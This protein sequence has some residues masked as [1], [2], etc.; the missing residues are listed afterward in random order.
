LT[1]ELAELFDQLYRDNQAKVYRLALSLTGNAHDAEEITQEAFLRAF[2]SYQG[3]REE[4]SFFTWIYRIAINVAN[5]YLKHRTK[6]PIN[7]LT[8][9]QG[10]SLEEIIDPN[11]AN[12]PETELLAF[13][14][15][16]K[17]LHAMTECL[18]ID[19]RKVFCLAITLG[20]P[21]KTIAEI[22]DC[23]VGSVK[24]TLHRAKK[25]WFGYMENKCQ[26]I[27]K[28]NPCNCRQF[29]RFGLKQ[30]WISKD[31]SVNPRPSATQVREEVINLRTLRDF[32]QDLYQDQADESF[33]QRIREGIKNKEWSIFS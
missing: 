23:S 10:Y 21:H 5:D 15:R 22:L 33:A 18:P 1:E 32:Y 28:S 27:R 2:R 30:G 26:L 20:L 12:N 7:S 24:T 19:Q 14:A 4:S 9:D 25:R 29:V 11:P 6:L 16:I 31:A 13:Q 8:E 17:C 3:F